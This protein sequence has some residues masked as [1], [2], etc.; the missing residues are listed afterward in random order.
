MRSLRW[1]PA[2]S[3]RSAGFS[4]VEL[5]V[6]MII[7]GVL[8]AIAIPL[9]LHQRASAHDASTQADVSSLGKEIAAY[10]V[11]GGSGLALDLDVELGRAVLSDDSGIRTSL[12]LT[13]G[14][15]RPT[16]GATSRL[17]DERAWCV[18]LTD[19]AGDVQ[20]YRYTATDGLGEGTC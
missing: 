9:L 1:P 20:E 8:A 7:V 19:P 2:G 4:L 12:P 6:V 15:A 18:S 17:D 11:D 13:N 5:L 14:T 16:S 10:Y 3:A